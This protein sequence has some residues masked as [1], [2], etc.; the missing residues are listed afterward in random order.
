MDEV[1]R[2][3]FVLCSN[4][5][6]RARVMAASDASSAHHQR[7]F[8]KKALKDEVC[9][10]RIEIDSEASAAFERWMAT[11]YGSK[12]LTPTLRQLVLLGFVVKRWSCLETSPQA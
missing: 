4:D 8:G 2:V 9:T 5:D 7:Y 1:R 11:R 6:L 3:G 12:G 10:A